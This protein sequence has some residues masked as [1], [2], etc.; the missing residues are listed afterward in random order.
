M[1]VFLS[2][3]LLD[4][5]V[6]VRVRVC[7]TQGLMHARQRLHAKPLSG[8]LHVISLELP[9]NPHLGLLCLAL[10]VSTLLSTLQQECSF[11]IKRKVAMFL[12]LVGFLNDSSSPL[13]AWLVIP[14]KMWFFIIPQAQLSVFY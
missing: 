6:R 14:I 5:Y 4:E 7:K 13:N 8:N 9:R 1:F 2:G 12:P 3:N 10:H 11:F